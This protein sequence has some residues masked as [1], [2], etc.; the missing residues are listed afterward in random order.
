MQQFFEGN[1]DPSETAQ[2]PALALIGQVTETNVSNH[3]QHM[4]LKF[5]GFLLAPP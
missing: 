1:F 3:K 5:T 2:P 4:F